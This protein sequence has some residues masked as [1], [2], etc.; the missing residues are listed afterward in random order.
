MSAL[1]RIVYFVIIFFAVIIFSFIAGNFFGGWLQILVLALFV[2]VL[3]FVL[4]Y[5]FRKHMG[6]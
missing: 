2:A 4:D 5:V 1:N 6:G 3:V